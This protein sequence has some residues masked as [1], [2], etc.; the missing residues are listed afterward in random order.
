MTTEEQEKKKARSLWRIQNKQAAREREDKAIQ[1]YLEVKYP[2]LS[3]IEAISKEGLH[4]I[5][6]LRKL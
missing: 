5:E 4:N 3:K 1:A 2:N 6:L